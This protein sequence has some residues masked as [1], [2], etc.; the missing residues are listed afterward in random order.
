MKKNIKSVDPATQE[1]LKWTEKEC[2]ETIWDRTKLQEPHCGFGSLGV[3][4]KNCNLGPCRIDPFG[5]GAKYGVCGADKD[6]IAA[7]NLLR[8]AISGSACHNDHGRDL[9]LAL[10]ALSEGKTQGYSIKAEEK[11]KKVAK[12]YGVEIENKSLKEIAGEFAKKILA[13][14]GQQT[15]ELIFSHRAPKKRQELWRKLGI[16]P[17]GIDREITESL[18]RT[19]IGVDNDYKSLVASIMKVSL[20]DG[21]G[22]SMVATEISDILFGLPAPV[23]AKMN[24]G[25]LK[26]DEVNIL[27][28]GHV[29][30]LSDVVA[31][32]ALDEELIKKAKDKGAKGINVAGICCTANEVLVRKG[33][34]VAGNFLQ[35]ELA[36]ATGAVDL[37]LVDLQCVMPSL[38]RVAESFHTKIISTHEKARFPGVPH[39]EFKEERAVD[40]AKELIETAIDNFTNRDKERVHIPQETSDAVVGFTAE[41]IFRHLG[42]KYRSSYRPLN[43]A[44]IEGRIRGVVGVV[45]CDN[46]KNQSG[47][48]HTKMVKELIAHDILVIQTGCAA[49]AC[50]KSGLL[51]PEAALEYAGAGL[52]EVCEAVGIPPVLHGGACVD[53]SRILIECCNI[54]NE[55]GLGE[56]FSDLPIAGAA[57]EWMSE[58]AVAIGWYVVASGL[59]VLFG[60]PLPVLGSE[61]LTRYI[62]KDLFD[63]I[64]AGWGFEE[65]PV[66]G[67]HV[68]IEHINKKREKLNL[69]PMMHEPLTSK[70][71]N[72]ALVS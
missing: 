15:G 33:I 67:A 1:M 41:G 22:G 62:T 23:R 38:A 14:Y 66:K 2:I 45:G 36:L 46:P 71:D 9:A 29:P 10:L 17:R 50:G 8:H 30:L 57:P 51:R 26:E 65:D 35:Q 54:L 55:G 34:P 5:E 48:S 52:R 56:D 69:R 39:V 20:S 53:N 64:G 42:G 37:M 40:Q 18:S 60:S 16:M 61:N 47:G 19:N 72:D 59:F 63:I 70:K 24:L 21:W 43:N 7:R 49:V 31:E 58:K 4:C 32:T 6:A 25:V 68:L 13:E 44:I 27:L 11:L 12:E 28:H 3:C